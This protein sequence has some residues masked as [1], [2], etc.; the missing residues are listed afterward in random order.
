MFFMISKCD[1]SEKN[2]K[3]A[4]KVVKNRKN[5]LLFFLNKKVLQKSSFIVLLYWKPEK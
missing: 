3:N 5:D 1:F 2:G 4:S